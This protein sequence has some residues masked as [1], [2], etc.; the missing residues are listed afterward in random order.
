[1]IEP[2]EFEKKIANLNKK[3]STSFGEQM[4]GGKSKEE[5][6][7]EHGKMSFDEAMRQGEIIKSQMP[8]PSDEAKARSARTHNEGLDRAVERWRKM[9][10]EEYNVD[11]VEDR[12][13][14]IDVIAM[15][16]EINN[17]Y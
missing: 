11:I 6:D 13:P 16:K 17:D 9:I 2:N 3:V 1:M 10:Q 5:Y 7:K 4:R 14:M 12:I 8:E 15:I